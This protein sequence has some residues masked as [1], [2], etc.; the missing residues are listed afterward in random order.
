MYSR[1]KRLKHQP[2]ESEDTWLARLSRRQ[3]VKKTVCA[4]ADKICRISWALLHNG[5]Y[6]ADERC[7]FG[8]TAIKNKQIR[9]RHMYDS[10]IT[11]SEEAEDNKYNR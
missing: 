5:E 7:P 8:I 1:S 2:E 3:P 11:I 9:T 10:I 6:Y 4:A